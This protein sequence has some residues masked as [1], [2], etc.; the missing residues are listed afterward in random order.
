[1]PHQHFPGRFRDPP[2]GYYGPLREVLA[3][4]AGE[5]QP[6]KRGP[7]PINAAVERREARLL[8]AEKA[9]RLASVP[10]GCASRSR[11]LANPGVS[12]RSAPFG[13]R[14]EQ[15]HGALPP[16]F[17]GAEAEGYCPA[18]LKP[19][20][21]R[22]FFSLREPLKA[23]RK[24]RLCCYASVPKNRGTRGFHRHR[25]FR[26]RPVR[27]AH[28]RGRARLDDRPLGP[29]AR[30]AR[31]GHRV[32]DPRRERRAA[33]RLTGAVRA[34]DGLVR[35]RRLRLC[36]DLGAAPRRPG[37]SRHRHRRAALH[38]GI[39]R[40]KPARHAARIPLRQPLARGR[41]GDRMGR[42][43]G[44]RRVAL[45]RASRFL[46]DHAA[47]HRLRRPAAVRARPP[48]GRDRA[49]LRL[50]QSR[51]DAALRDPL[52]AL[53]PRDGRGLVAEA[54]DRRRDRDARRRRHHL[55]HGDR[56]D[57]W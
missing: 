18:P 28:D 43:R 26:S 6:R 4:R 50:D 31:R 54:A 5:S 11:G 12:R 8:F 34:L 38:P 13:L 49:L 14:G 55:G 32:P 39:H 30:A 45:F 22:G 2:W 36:V 10:G 15:G 42:V 40:H 25:A 35:V 9:A 52:A 47:L 51:A 19:L 16:G 46:R 44:A 1:M 33:L 3:R 17:P 7:E 29:L 53:D 27:R 56:P 24:L 57:A 37:R 23:N 48:A 21:L 41:D 20:S